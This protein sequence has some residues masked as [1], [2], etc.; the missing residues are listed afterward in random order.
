MHPR[1]KTINSII[2]INAKRELKDKST[3]E[4]RYYISS[5]NNLTPQDALKAIRQHWGIENTL[6]WF[7]DMPFNEDY[8]RIRKDDALNVMTIIRPSI[9]IITKL[10]AKKAIY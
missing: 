5:V 9:K 8:S 2:K 6:H 10:Q 1:W 7:L 3:Q 4:S